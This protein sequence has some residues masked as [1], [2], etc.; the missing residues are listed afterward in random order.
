MN[1][2]DSLLC[3]LSWPVVAAADATAPAASAGPGD[4]TPSGLRSADLVADAAVLRQAY[5]ALHPGL[6]R[7][8][9][10]GQMS[11][12]FD[13]LDRA[14]A[15][16]QSLAEAYLAFSVFAA[17]I[18][19]GHTYANFFNQTKAVAGALFERATCVPVH[20]VWLDRRMVVLRNF[21]S[22]PAIVP[23]TEI[24]AIDDIPV[25]VILE[26]LMTV[27]RADG[28]NDA[29]RIAWLQVEGDEPIEA[30][31]VFLPLFFPT[32]G[33]R[34]RLR[35]QEPGAASCRVTV[36][37]ALTA[38][39]RRETRPVQTAGAGP[40]WTLDLSDP[41]L[42]LLRMP[43][44]AMYNSRWDWQSWL[45]DAFD[46]LARA[47][48][49]ALVV[50]LRGNE[51]GDD[52]GNVLLAHLA[53]RPLSLDG[54]RRL[55]RYR[56]IPDALAPYLDTWDPSFKDWGDAAKP[57]DDRFFRL[58]RH[59]DH[60][61]GDRIEPRAPRYEGRVFVLIGATNSSATFDFARTVKRSGLA[62]LVGQPTGGNLRGINGGAFFFLRLPNSRIEL[63]L[64]LIGYFPDAGLPPDQGVDPDVLVER[65]VQDIS[66]NVD[67]ELRAV[68][69]ELRS[70]AR[71][72]DRIGQSGRF[73][74]S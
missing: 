14:L 53:A 5:E 31:D 54:S 30:F 25:A 49:P 58:T 69:R 23:G 15:R 41:E 70:P 35:V 17:R 67:A 16:D 13:A 8:N 63:D 56:R 73:L 9:T 71:T 29:K 64:P 44:W 19:C 21:S 11:A 38:A 6:L 55:V 72:I 57:F 61:D 4:T 12:H 1:R 28:H 39:R 22:D 32:I 68:R 45:Q 37:D 50:D 26:R 3:L 51:G 7:Y 27:A 24:Q 18:R 52:V 48:T 20:F 74:R 60:E 46:S 2:R 43:T 59:D 62:T 42:A 40:L 33:P 65:T 36:V 66:A 47:A 34:Q 10:A